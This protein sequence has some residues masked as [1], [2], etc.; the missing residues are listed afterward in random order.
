MMGVCDPIVVGR[1]I[2]HYFGLKLP[3]TRASSQDRSLEVAWH[4][5]LALENYPLEE[6]DQLNP[7]ILFHKVLDEANP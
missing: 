4:H 6:M 1:A 7:F 3:S 2:T 5:Q